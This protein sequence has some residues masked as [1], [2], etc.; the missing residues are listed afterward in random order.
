MSDDVTA[1]TLTSGKNIT[2][3]DDNTINLN[4]TFTVNSATDT[5]QQVTVDGTTSTITAGTDA[6]QVT[7]NGGNATITAGTGSNQV[8][9]DGSNGQVVI[10]DAAN[11]GIVMG[12]QD[13]TTTN[14][15]TE[16]GQYIT[17]LDNT[18]WDPNNYVA[19]RAATE[20]QL[21][22]LAGNISD[23]N[24]S[25]GEINN[26]KRSFVS[27]SG[28][29]IEL[30]KDDTLNLKGGA[31]TSSLT[32]GNIGVVNNEAGN[33]FDI[34]LSSK[35][36]GL[37]SVDTKTLTASDSITVGSGNT[38]TSIT[39][40][41]VTTTTVKTGNTTVNNSGVTI[42]ATDSSKS[43]IKLTNDTIS[44]GGNQVHNVAAGT[45][46]TDAVNVSQLNNV[47]TNIGNGMGEMN[48]RINRL[49]DRVDRVGAGAAALAALHPLD[50]DPDS[51]WEVAA[52][53]GNY[54]GASAVAVGAFYR[55]NNDTMFSIGS[56]YGGGENMVNA[57][58]TW[59]IG[60][61]ETK[62][63]SSK[64]AMAQEIDS[65]KSVVSQQNSKL[66]AQDQKIEELMAAVAELTKNK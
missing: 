54:R 18:T 65:L 7:V 39:G 16:S 19:D 15:S 53:V 35:L 41:T 60:Q 47:V 46:D 62:T 32:E 6:N 28:E 33:G 42:A 11:G 66:E 38:T 45:A 29:K 30:G 17:G 4:D 50:F 24:T 27:D 51:R 55:P 34:K 40:D 61:G 3:A 25:I 1:I 44:M 56:S 64:K 43:D 26:S 2:V 22:Q 36:S 63:Y 20:G 37:D 49:D 58:V 52:G 12:N 13:V 31:D 57:G 48:N 10:G 8:T 9:V 23:I 5:T 59:R 14:G 21:A